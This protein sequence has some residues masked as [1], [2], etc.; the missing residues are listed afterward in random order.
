MGLV[1]RFDVTH[2]ADTAHIR[3]GKNAVVR[4]LLYA[5]ASSGDD[6]QGAALRLEIPKAVVTDFADGQPAAGVEL[7]AKR[8]ADVDFLRAFVANVVLLFRAAGTGDRADR[9]AKCR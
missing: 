1:V 2:N 9:L 5:G 7:N 4:D 6:F 3:P 8:V